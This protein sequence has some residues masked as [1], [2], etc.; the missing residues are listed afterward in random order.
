MI[1]GYLSEDKFNAAEHRKDKQIG[2][3]ISLQPLWLRIVPRTASRIISS[4]KRVVRLVLI[5]GYRP[6]TRSRR[7]IQHPLTKTNETA[8]ATF[9]I[10]L[11]DHKAETVIAILESDRDAEPRHYDS[12]ATTQHAIV[13]AMRRIAKNQL[14]TYWDVLRSRSCHQTITLHVRKCPHGIFEVPRQRSAKGS[15]PCSLRHMTP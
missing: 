14:Q 4:G 8:P 6:D 13:R 9:Y 15:P 7:P 12:V 1:A 2:K 10:G 3:V 11:D 5:A